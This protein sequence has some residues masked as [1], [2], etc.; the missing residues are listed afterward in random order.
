MPKPLVNN[1]IVYQ[2]VYGR[3]IQHDL[4]L[5]QGVKEGDSPTFAN[6]TLNGDAYVGGNL[7]VQGNSTILNTN[8]I[9]FEDNIIL[10][11]RLESGSGVTLNQAGLEISRGHLQNYRIVFNEGDQTF[12]V[13]V[14]GNLQPVATREDTPLSYGVMI[15]NNV[16]KRL[17]S[18]NNISINLLLS[19]TT[20]SSSTSTG[21]LV[22]QGG[23]GLGKSA[24][25]GGKLFLRGSSTINSASIYTHMA[26]NNLLISSPNDIS[27]LPIG[28]VTLPY[29]KGLVFGTTEQS[30]SC[31]SVTRDINI[32]GGSD[33]NIHLDP[34]HNVSL[35][36]QI[37]ITFSTVNEKIYADSGNDMVITGR[38]NIQLVPG[39]NRN[40]AIP[41]DKPIVF[42][43]ANQSISAN[44]NNDLTLAAGNHILL[45][46]GPTLDVRIPTDN[47]IKL[48][49]SG[50]QR[51]YANSSNELNVLSTG[52]IYLSPGNSSHVNIPLNV[53]LTLGGYGQSLVADSVGNLIVTA[54][55]LI[56]VSNTQLIIAQT[57]DAVNGSSGSFYTLGGVGV[58]GTIYSETKMIVDSNDANALTIRRNNDNQTV[59]LV[60]NSGVGQ[61]TVNAGNG[62]SNNPALDLYSTSIF[63]AFGLIGLRAPFDNTAGY[64]IGRGTSTLNS[65]RV[66]T[67]NLPTYNQYSNAGE[68]PKFIVTSSNS[69][70]VLFSVESETGNIYSKGSFGL[71]NTQE[72]ENASTASFVITGGL[73]VNK[74]IYTNGKLVMLTNGTGA[75]MIRDASDA[76]VFT[77]DTT[78]KIARFDSRLE[79]SGTSGNVWAINNKLT[80]NVDTNTLTHDFISRFTNT[81]DSTD[82]SNGSVTVSGGVGI[83]QRLNVG[84]RAT[85]LSQLDMSNQKM[86]N[87]A[88]PQ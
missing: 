47:A 25:I 58:H 32:R 46:P 4:L 87:I 61:I 51:L 23:L 72:A 19:S 36:N 14:I 30:V 6:L 29:D 67:V 80:A 28:N 50:N 84:G 77:V 64:T 20:E 33:L 16:A 71:T 52:D 83:N 3:V 85:F 13:G 35:P 49:G 59:L 81:N 12:R 86:V 26:N 2:N 27:L 15:W 5:S 7:Y 24:S 65:G 21:S 70:D 37:P 40:V 1:K 44:I 60:D 9:E 69:S 88:N 45:T 34:G 76:P 18:T 63:N 78:N 66:L 43:N 22:L 10:L 39:N 11:N 74:S 79:I 57:S 48:G 75:I 55:G 31:N 62:T 82:T 8:V 17:D 42:G 54:T 41:V 73:G 53:P 68:T 56:R 38:Q